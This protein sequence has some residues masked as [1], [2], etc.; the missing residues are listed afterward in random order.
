METLI[1]PAERLFVPHRK[2]LFHSYIV[3][4]EGARELRLYYG[5]KEI[6]FDDERYFAFGEQLMSHGAFTAQAA[7][8][9]GPGYAW[10]EVRPFLEALVD[11]GILQRGEPGDDPRGTGLTA[12]PLPPSQCPEPRMWSAATCE[13][14]TRDLAGR[15]V[16]IGY[17][18]AIMPGHRIAH[19]ALDGDGRQVGEAN[20]VPSRLRLDRDTEWRV[21]QYPG[22]R[23]RDDG[24][25]NVTALKAMI[26]HWKPIMA[27]I[28]AVRGALRE[29]FGPSQAPGGAWTIGELHA[30]ACVVLALPAYQLL[31]AQGEPPP[32]H[33]VL[34][35]LFRITDGI[36]MTTSAMVMS[37]GHPLR[38][39][40]PVTGDEVHAYAEQY[41]MLISATGVCAGPKHLIDEFLRTAVD[42]APPDGIADLALP[43]EVDALLA[44][45]PAAIDYGLRGFQVWAVTF[46]LWLAMSRAHQAL[47][48]IAE[49]AAGDDRAARLAARLR[50]GL[51]AMQRLQIALDHDRSVHFDTFADAYAQARR[52]ARD[53]I[54]P[55][56][57]AEAIAPVLEGPAH[58]AAA[59]ELRRLLRERWPGER[60]AP[61]APDIER[62][63][64]EVLGYLREEQAVLALTGELQAAINR[65]FGRPQPTRAL[66]GRDLLVFHILHDGPGS[67]PYL[68]DALEDELGVA[69]ACTARDLEV[70]DSSRRRPLPAAP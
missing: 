10:D 18:E 61:G 39:D 22:S 24:P 38:A 62:I 23:F 52:A 19:P 46:S 26:K 43:A 41:G 53:R 34:S 60:D 16:E 6:S 48:A 36:R 69:I 11:E 70:L 67:F 32:L 66:T 42:G 44:E 14:I 30:L 33:P 7:T 15:A 17:L 35:S 57:L 58:R 64:G 28:V 56:T 29:R 5:I 25:M 63:A 51:P 3:N 50:A 59:A 47:L 31:R 49:A 40:A 37:V 65:D 54:G 8:G 27:V 1:E 13:S 45:L 4:D 2:R 9:W 21:C 55:P 68:L 20:V 12:S